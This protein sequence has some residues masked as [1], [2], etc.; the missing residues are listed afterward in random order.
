VKLRPFTLVLTLGCAGE[1][2]PPAAPDLV[3][4]IVDTLRA[5]R[6][7]TYGADR[8]T[9]P[10][11]DAMAA[12]GL[13]FERAYAQSGWTLPSVTS[14]LTG[15]FFHEHRVGR[16]LARP[17]VVG[18]LSRQATTLPELLAAQGYATGAVINNTFLAPEFGLRQGFVH[19]DYEGASN[20]SHRSA[21]TSVNAGLDWLSAQTAPAFLLLHVMEPH[22]DYRPDPAVRGRFAPIDAVPSELDLADPAVFTRLQN[23][24]NLPSPAGQAYVKALYDEEVA[25]VDLAIGRL[26]E[27]LAARGR[28]TV[29]ALTADHGEEHW[30]HAGFE[31]GHA[32]WSELTRVPLILQGPGIEKG[33]S[34]TVVEHVDLFATLLGLG[35]ASRPAGAHGDDLR[36]VAASPSP[37]VALSENCLYAAPCVS[38]VDDKARLL[39]FPVE[40]HMSAHLLDARGAD[41]PALQGEALRAEVNRLG[42]VLQARRGTLDP[43]NANGLR[44]LDAQLFEQLAALGYMNGVAVDPEAAQAGDPCGEPTPPPPTP[45]R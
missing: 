22:L 31:H 37:R 32:L 28:P 26:R 13:V 30:D 16:D 36:Q 10:Q 27:G 33:R 5:D 7:G 19:Y 11:I 2:A 6:L 45:G 25:T 1:V 12:E 38:L 9:S 34:A 3:L 20:A 8:P 17:N 40:Q 43:I 35:G 24:A 39:F 41:G 42:P 44:T 18:C 23:G 15:Q 4:V 29:V 14:L 21:L